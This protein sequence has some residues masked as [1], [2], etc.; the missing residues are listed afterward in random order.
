MEVDH[1]PA[2]ASL[3]TRMVDETS[4]TEVTVASP[5]EATSST[6][7]N[8]DTDPVGGTT[9]EITTAPEKSEGS[10]KSHEKET[11]APFSWAG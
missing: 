10:G 4:P 2:H 9:R 7:V 3:P 5:H 8:I 1:V 6:S 11:E